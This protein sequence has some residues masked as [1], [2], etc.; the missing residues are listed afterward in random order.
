MTHFYN[1][2]FPPN[3]PLDPRLSTLACP[4]LVPVETLHENP[5][6]SV[7]NRGG[8][9][10]VEYRLRQV[11]VLPVV[12][13]DSIA[14]V[15]VKRPVIND[16][17]LELPAGALEKDEDVA[18]GA[19]RE[20]L[21]ETGI[22]VTNLDRF[23]SMA[24]ISVSSTRNPNLS[25]IFKVDISEKEYVNRQP[26]DDEIYSVERLAIN[27]LAKKMASGEIYV[28]LTLAVLGIFLASR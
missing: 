1:A 12:N 18:I 5:W 23:I 13:Q 24:P 11:V 20:L 10:T 26:H 4:E 2:S 19:V 6:Y 25:Y 15:R 16:T 28:S 9:F 8:F 7:R 27:D 14:M 22:K 17:P 21:E 3:G